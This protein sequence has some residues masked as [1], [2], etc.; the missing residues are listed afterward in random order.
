M[1]PYL[2]QET[3]AVQFNRLFEALQDPIGIFFA[4]AALVA[5]TLLA[6][7]RRSKWSM[8]ALLLFFSP[9]MI[10][11]GTLLNQRAITPFQQFRTYGRPICGALLVFLLIPTF[12][13]ERGWRQRVVVFPALAF[14][15]LELG[16]AVRTLAGGS[17]LRGT[18]SLGVYLLNFVIMAVGFSRWLQDWRDVRAAL[19]AAAFGALMLTG[20]T[21]IQLVINRSAAVMQ[22][23]LFGLTGNPQQVGMILGGS[24]P[25]VVMLAVWKEEVKAM[26][27]VWAVT[28]AMMAVLLGWSGSRTGGM[29]A[30][31]GLGM[32]FR[33]HLG[34]FMI[35]GVIGLALVLA[36]L[37]I[38]EFDVAKSSSRLLDP[39]NT[40]AQVWDRML[41]D[42]LEHPMAGVTESEAFGSENSYLLAGARMGII[43][44]LILSVFIASVV[45]MLFR[46]HAY[47]KI[48]RDVPLVVDLVIGGLLAYF[49]GAAF[50]GILFGTLSH[51][52]FMIFIYFALAGFLI[53][54]VEAQASASSPMTEE[55]EQ[56]PE[57][58]EQY[59]THGVSSI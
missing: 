50:E 32:L 56:H 4:L 15:I 16:F 36:M 58:F 10:A 17:P 43:G 51:Q 38:F 26:R 23:R 39:T 31:I 28:A 14:L 7:G 35:F 34:T 33:R 52:V 13:A 54:L 42:F 2:N 19:R 8:I 55:H 18:L 59:A 27:T 41:T 6:S 44:L 29:M 47:R 45:Y 46:L 9:M 12:K 5:L 3:P 48:L 22:G 20:A 21:S 24:I 49:A 57:L 11:A 25:I 30:V 1:N 53:D 40:R 37:Q